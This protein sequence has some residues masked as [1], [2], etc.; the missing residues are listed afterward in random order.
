MP[1]EWIARVGLI[2]AIILP[3]W[4]IP[5]I[6]RIIQRKSS[7]DISLWWVLGVWTC[8]VL[9]FPAGLRSTDVVW[10]TFNIVN[11]VFFTG[12]VAVTLRYRKRKD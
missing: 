2:A 9:M 11:F 3:F 7:A 1:Q 5:L 6:L 8:I 12:V 10:R 4:N